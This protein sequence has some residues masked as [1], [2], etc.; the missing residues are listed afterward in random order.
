M[1]YKPGER[2]SREGFVLS[3]RGR[4]ILARKK[5][6]LSGVGGTSAVMGLE[7]LARA[8]AGIGDRLGKE[9]RTGRRTAS[10]E[11]PTTHVTRVLKWSELDS[12]FNPL[13]STRSI[14]RSD[15]VNCQHEVH[16]VELESPKP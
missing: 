15:D 16:S 9:E 12:N 8:K 5:K 2:E 13:P 7:G 3:R 4:G 11:P 14:E 1:Q 6:S 10:H